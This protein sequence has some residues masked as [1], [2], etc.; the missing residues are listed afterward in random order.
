[1]TD[2]ASRSEVGGHP[3]RWLGPAVLALVVLSA[4]APGSGEFT[5]GDPAGFFAGFWH[6]LISLVTLIWS[7]FDPD[8]SI[9]EVNNTGFWYDAGFFL[10]I[11]GV[12]AGG[13]AGSR[14]R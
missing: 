4:C 5:A 2:R 14:R 1:M 9:Y 6:G 8:I 3:L 12:M 10:S 13:G 7:I 11:S